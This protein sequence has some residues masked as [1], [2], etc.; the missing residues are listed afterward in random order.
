M[1]LHGLPNQVCAGENR[2]GMGSVARYRRWIDRWVR[3]IG[4]QRVVVFLEPD[5]L[6]ASICLSPAARRDRFALMTYAARRL[7]RLPP[8]GVYEDGGAGDWLGVR[9]T[10]RLLRAGGVRYARGFALNGKHFDW[11]RNEVR[12]GTKVGRLLG[13]K[14]FVVNTAFNG[15]GPETR[16][17]YHLWCNPRG[18]ALGPLPTTHTHSALADAFFWLGAPGA[19]DGHCNGGPTVGAFWTNWAVDLVHNAQRA[20]DFPTLGAHLP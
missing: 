19:S 15:R 9:Q 16:G 4:S 14:H 2:P 20:P 3:R 10:V 18:R 5:A 12:F 8:T 7:S 1:T 17:R 11:T 13:G 6:P